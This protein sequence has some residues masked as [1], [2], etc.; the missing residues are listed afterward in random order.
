MFTIICYQPLLY[1]VYQRHHLQFIK[2]LL[3]FEDSRRDMLI[4][5]IREVRA[6]SQSNTAV[7]CV[8]ID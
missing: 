7:H 5:T 2:L 8:Y 6:Q 1:I 4:N 3:P